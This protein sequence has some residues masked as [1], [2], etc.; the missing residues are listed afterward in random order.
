MLQERTEGWVTGLQL[1]GFALR[2]RSR[3][4]VERFL[5]EL[6]GS[7][8][9]GDRYL[10]EEVLQRQPDDVRSFLLRTSILD[11]FT[12]GL[13]DAVTEA[14][15]GEDMIR[16]CERDNLFIIPLDGHGAWYRFHN[17]FADALREGLSRT[18]TEEENY[19]LHQRASRWLEDNGHLE[20]AIRHSIAGHVWDRAVRLLED[21]CATLFEGDDVV[22]LRT[23]LQG[24][25]P[26][27]LESSPRLAFW[28]AWALGRTGRW[29][30]GA[31]PLRIAQDAWSPAD[32]RSGEGLNLLWHAW[33]ALYGLD[34]RR[35][36]DYAQRALDL[37]PE[38]RPT[39]RIIAM[40]AQGIAR[41]NH[42]EPASAEATFADVRMAIDST[43]RSWLQPWEMAHSAAVM[44]QQGKL[45]E[46]TVL[47]RRVI[48]SGG[49]RPTKLWVQVALYQIGR[50]YLEW[51]LLDDAQRCLRKADDLAE[52][53]QAL[54]WRVRIRV[55]LA[56]TA[57]AQGKTE[58]A[59]DEVEQAI[60][61]ANQLGA[62]QEIRSARAE[63]A[64]FWLASNQVALARRWAD[65]CE[66]DPYVPPEYER[67]VEHLTYA[68]LLIKEGRP[69]LALRAL[70]HIDRKAEE[71][72]RHGERVEVLI[73][74]AL[75]HKADGNSLEAFKSL[76]GALELGGPGGYLRVFVDEGED[77]ASLLRHAAARVGH[78]DYV[79]RLLTEIGRWPIA[80][81]P[82]PSGMPDA[83]SEREVEVL[84][85]VAAGLPNRE[86]GQRLFISEKTV[87]THLSNIMG[88]LGAANRTQAVDQ[89]RRLGLF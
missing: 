20:D 16:R 77:L 24:L 62:L 26:T 75:A 18:A 10:W 46:S 34:N 81:Q 79:Q 35:A 15:D 8:D 88:K 80:E 64:R 11:R 2:G 55:G 70:Q 1:V 27:V 4:L 6:V 13:C 36:I 72:G 37:L 33:R 66:L 71:A 29:N 40:M 51:G 50:I 85:L 23:W 53:T 58:E 14:H 17:L 76:N 30:E 3:D 73:L 68:R 47:C 45:L 69:D 43:G 25:P 32:D 57:W 49:E 60:R 54:Q 89:A 7:T 9:F 44:A 84:R 82:H 52:M 5:D 67:Q 63:Q 61:F 39:E 59:L 31:R 41:L 65:S 38:S 22:T 74:T 42:G 87:K 21:F 86:V 19:L 28:L 78:R 12:A 56:G 48:Q 83:L